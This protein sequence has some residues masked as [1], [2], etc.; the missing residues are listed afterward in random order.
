MGKPE[1]S[2]SESP[3]LMQES[4]SRQGIASALDGFAMLTAEQ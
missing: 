4:K 2:G 3:A 1:R